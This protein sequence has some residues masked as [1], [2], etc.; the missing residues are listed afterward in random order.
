MLTAIAEVRG[1]IAR[2][3]LLPGQEIRLRRQALIRMTHSSTGI[4]GNL[5]NVR[6]VEALYARQKIDAPARDIFEVENYLGTLRYIGQV[7][8]QKKPITEKVILRIHR[9]VTDRILP[10]EQSGRYRTSPVYV[11]R[12]RR[13]LPRE[14]VYTAPEAKRVPQLVAGLVEWLRKSEKDKI[15]PIVAAGIAHQELAAI[16][17]FSDGNGRTARA[18]ATLILYERGYDFRRLFA[19]EDYYNKD[20]PRY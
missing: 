19:L 20:R 1:V 13:G 9:L 14:V 8:E 15:H 17:P 18:L 2:A 6:Q 3:K 16:H 11:V 10:G 5:L 4:E 7:V 12:R